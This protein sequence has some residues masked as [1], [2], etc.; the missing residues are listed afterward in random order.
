MRDV[1][2]NGAVAGAAGGAASAIFL[3]LVGER[4]I[5]TAVAIEARANAGQ[6]HEEMFSRS[7]QHLGGMIGITLAGVAFGVL[8]AVLFARLRPRLP[9]RADWQRALWL[10]A[11]VWVVANLVPAL[12]YPPNPPTVG[13]PA[14]IGRRT[15]AY[16]LLL[17]FSVLAAVAATGVSAWCA[18]RGTD[19]QLR[20]LATVGTFAVLVTIALL[21]FPPTPDAVHAPTQL[22]WRFRIQSLGGT[23]LLWLTTATV[24]G[25]LVTEKQ[26][27]RELASA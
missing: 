10:G 19:D 24:L 25:R 16:L 21:M 4:S 12:K 18:K 26:P 13:D 20:L 6:A 7:T 2:R 3:R 27:D 15:A 5:D 8:L 1:L 14:T 17:L 23:A 11:F 22:V 9:G